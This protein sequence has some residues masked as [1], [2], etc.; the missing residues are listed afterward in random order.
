MEGRK[1]KIILAIAGE[2]ASGKNEMADY[3]AKKHKARAYRLSEVL[4]DILHRL[5]LSESRENMQ[6]VSTMLREYFGADIISKVAVS[7]LSKIKNRI[8]AINGVRRMSD[9]VALKKHFRVKLIYIK[10][11]MEKRYARIVKRSENPDDKKKTFNEFKKDHTKE[12]EEQIHGLEKKADA[13]IENNGTKKEFWGKIDE[14]I[15]RINK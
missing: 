4:R 6:N 1:K 2:I 12:A 9:I 3:V 7:D 10:S 11:D 8:I 5:D 14:V 15:K 13:V